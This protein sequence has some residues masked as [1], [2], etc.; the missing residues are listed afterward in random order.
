MA[1][2][3]SCWAIP[4]PSLNSV[5][6]SQPTW[7]G[8]LL[9]RI[10]RSDTKVSL[11]YISTFLKKLLFYWESVCVCVCTCTKRSTCVDLKVSSLR[12]PSGIWDTLR[13][14]GKCLYLLSHFTGSFC[15]FPS[16]YLY[17]YYLIWDTVW[18]CLP[19]WPWTPVSASPALKSQHD[20]THLHSMTQHTWCTL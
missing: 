6:A 18:L 5:S 3:L 10:C 13:L 9:C 19:G 1:G 15:G 12:P 8:V 20:S 14:S 2:T 11:M 17:A 7:Q 16:V 4:L